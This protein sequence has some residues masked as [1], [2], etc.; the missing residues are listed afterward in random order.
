MKYGQITF[1][2]AEAVFNKLGGVDGVESFLR[3]ELVLAPATK[4][5][6]P[7]WKTLTLGNPCSVKAYRASLLANSYEIGSYA[8]EILNKVQVADTETEAKLV[9]VT[10]GEL[11]FKNS[12]TYGEIVS[13]A[14]ELGLELCPAEVG[15]K[16]RLEYANQPKDE[17]LTV[18]MEPI[19]DSDGYRRV[20]C[21]H[22]SSVGERW[23][24]AS[25]VGGGGR[26]RAGDRFVFLSRK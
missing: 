6:F 8:N 26:W 23:L 16:L 9:Q 3:G 7:V 10:V 13:R 2:Q 21:V 5:A 20:F 12:A 17:F 11:G 24:S 22:R 15:P 19:V 25:C 14:R 4:P 18:A 1:G